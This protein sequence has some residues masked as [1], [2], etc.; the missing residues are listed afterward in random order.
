MVS[1]FLSSQV[2]CFKQF[3]ELKNPLNISYDKMN[4]QEKNIY[5]YVARL[6]M[7]SKTENVSKNQVD[8]G[9]DIK[10]FVYYG[11]FCSHLLVS[12]VNFLV[13]CNFVTVAT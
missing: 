12:C 11:R 5:R 2:K 8:A 3:K 6:L 7:A 10:Y 1:E 4:K 9:T 13:S